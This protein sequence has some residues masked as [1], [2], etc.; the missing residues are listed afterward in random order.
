MPPPEE[1]HELT[2]DQYVEV[3]AMWLS[4][5]IRMEAEANR[6]L[7]AYLVADRERPLVPAIALADIERRLEESGV[8]VRRGPMTEAQQQRLALSENW[9]RSTTRVAGAKRTD[10]LQPTR[11][12]PRPLPEAP[13]KL[14]YEQYVEGAA[15]MRSREIELVMTAHRLIF[16]ML[17]G[18][19][20]G[21]LL[22]GPA[23]ADIEAKLEQMRQGQTS[24]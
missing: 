5:D 23:F 2:Y 1:N 11:S 10:S 8:Q 13:E 15:M 6:L 7:F 14:T 12:L 16:M 24:S 18:R 19:R 9:F 20:D 21:R 17:V 3:M 22:P 4:G